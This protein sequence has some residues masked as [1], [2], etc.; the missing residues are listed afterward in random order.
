MH[1]QWE[2]V[3][4]VAATKDQASRH[5]APAAGPGEAMLAAIWQSVQ[6]REYLQ[7]DVEVMGKESVFA[8]EILIAHLQI[9][10]Q[11]YSLQ[12]LS[13][14]TKREVFQLSISLN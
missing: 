13:L 7:A 3:S 4:R 10:T 9:F 12:K 1:F 2:N 6:K 8:V 5:G 11:I 14:G